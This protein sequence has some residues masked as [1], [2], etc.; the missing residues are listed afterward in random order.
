MKTLKL[1]L[2]ALLFAVSSAA[3]AR[4]PEPVVDLIDQPAATAS[5][6]KLTAEDVKQLIAKTAADKKWAVTSVKEG[7]LTASLTW[8]QNKHTIVINISY[9]ADLYSLTYKDSVN[10]KYN[11]ND[12]RV[13]EN[14]YGKPEIHPYYNRYVRSLNQAIQAELRRM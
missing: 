12:V 8:N 2:F 7:L 13:F 1:A 6:K 11:K 3:L 10:M 4:A 5:G 9:S 14:N